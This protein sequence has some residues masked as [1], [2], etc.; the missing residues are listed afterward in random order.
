MPA[1]RERVDR[2]AAEC[3]RSLLAGDDGWVD[4]ADELARLAVLEDD[5]APASRAIFSGVVELL[6]DR[7]E[8]AAAD[9]YR[10]FFARVLS[11]CAGLA[12]DPAREPGSAGPI[13]E[14]AD[15]RRVIVPSRV[16]VGADV[17]LTIPAVARI[18]DRY[19]DAEVFFWGGASSGSLLPRDSRVRFEPFDYPRRGGL[20]ARLEAWTRMRERIAAEVWDEGTWVLDLDTRWSQAGML[21]LTPGDERYLFWESRSDRP[22]SSAPLAELASEWLANIL[23][24]GHP[25]SGLAIEPAD[26]GAVDRPVAVVNF[27]VGGNDAKRLG[28]AFERGV[29]ESLKDAGYAVLLDQGFGPQEEARA[30]RIAEGGAA[31]LRKTTIAELAGLIAG[32]DLYVGYDSAGGHIAASLGVRAIDVFAGAVSPKMVERWSPWGRRAA[33]VIAV[34]AGESDESVLAR[35]RE[36][37]A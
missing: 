19:S 6:A 10:R 9:A 5:E 26:L 17:A 32:A 36:R 33:E 8:P 27:G 35:V 21:P 31:E 34:E 12:F 13:A 29:L 16:T 11:H 14:G 24:V 3:L 15:V 1:A 30:R 18:L 25:P 23:G 37:L 22:E 4:P 2:L 7:F 28:E 20:R